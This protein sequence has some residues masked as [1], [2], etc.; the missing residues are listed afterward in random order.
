[1]TIDSKTD[2]E[3]LRSLLAETAKATNELKCSLG[4]VQKA[5]ARLSFVL[6]LA[7]TLIERSTDEAS[8]D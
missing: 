6:A 4:D 7:N 1:M 3:L 5:Q 8:K 2:S